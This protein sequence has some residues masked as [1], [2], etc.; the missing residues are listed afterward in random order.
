ME[1]LLGLFKRSSFK[2]CYAI[3]MQSGLIAY[4]QQDLS[5]QDFFRNHIL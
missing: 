2:G 5:N 1:Q 4:I 3:F